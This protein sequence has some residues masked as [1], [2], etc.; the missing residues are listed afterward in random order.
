MVNMRSVKFAGIIAAAVLLAGFGGTSSAQTPAAV[1]TPAKPKSTTMAK[2]ATAATATYDR[3]LLRP[4]LLKD[5]APETFQVKFET[6]RGDF[7]VTVNRAWAPVAADRFYNLVKHHYFD[8]ARFFRVVPNFVVQ[9]GISAYPPVTA[10][11]Q[12]ATIKDEPVTQKNLRGTLTFAKTDA[13][14]SRTT[15]IFINLKDNPSL[16][17]QGFA[18]FGAVDGHGMSVVDTFYG[19]YGDSAGL[20]QEPMEKQGEKYIAQKWPLLDAIKHALLV[21]AA[22]PKPAAKTAAKPATAKPSTGSTAKPAANPQ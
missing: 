9:F 18:P 22:A 8:S 12:K 6:T 15:E 14:N 16:D 11:W 20:D 10:A 1:Q 7:T 19:Q 17:S 13:P 4:A 3:A 21:G 2:P 5:K